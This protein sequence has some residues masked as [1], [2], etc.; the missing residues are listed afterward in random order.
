MEY[1]NTEDKNEAKVARS[2]DRF[3]NAVL[4]GCVGAWF[5]VVAESILLPNGTTC[6]LKAFA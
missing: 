3:E 5:A 1:R 4:R 2:T 6:P